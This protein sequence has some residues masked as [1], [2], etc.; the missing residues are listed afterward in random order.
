MADWRTRLI[1]TE[2]KVPGGFRSLATPALPNGLRD[3][4]NAES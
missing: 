4:G 3:H 2:S 1:H